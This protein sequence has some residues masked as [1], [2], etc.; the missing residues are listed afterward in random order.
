MS[1]VCLITHTAFQKPKF[2]S[3]TYT[4]KNNKEKK[5]VKIKYRLTHNNHITTKL[6]FVFFKVSERTLSDTFHRSHQSAEVTMASFYRIDSGS[7]R[8]PSTL[9]AL[10]E[11]SFLFQLQLQEKEEEDSSEVGRHDVNKL[12]TFLCAKFK[13]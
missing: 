1:N 5:W 8:L 13:S 9:S 4:E 11:Q 7:S 12:C 10:E 6:C 3:L 2:V